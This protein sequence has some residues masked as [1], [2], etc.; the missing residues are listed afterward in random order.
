MSD[1][2]IK[3]TERPLETELLVYAG[4][5]K[6]HR[7]LIY[8]IVGATFVLSVIVSLLLPKAYISTASVFPP[9]QEATI[10]SSILSSQIPMA[11]MGGALSGFLGLKSPADLW[12]G[13]L[14]S[15]TVQDEI[16][17]RFNL[18]EIYGKEKIEDA[19][20]ALEKKI[21][22]SKTKEEIILISVEDRD[23][24]AAARMANA[25]VE[26]LD[27]INKQV[28]MSSGKRTRIFIEKRLVEAREELKKIEG[29]IKSFMEA[30]R[31]VKLDD[32]TRVIIES[33]GALKGQL[34]AKEL[35]YQTIASYAASTNPQVEILKT[36]VDQLRKQLTDLDQGNGGQKDIFMPMAKIP[37]IA[38]RYTTLIRDAKIQETLFELL[39]QQYEMAKIQES[40]DSPIIQVLDYANPPEKKSKPR[41]GLIVATATFASLFISVLLAFL[42]QRFER[43]RLDGGYL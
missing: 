40:K 10:G 36:Q 22:I 20:K 43:I 4:T 1:E 38:E 5:I 9:Q 19:R 3:V 41:R 2:I 33:I 21:S 6:R 34:M 17:K 8:S 27:K 13:I 15:H 37:K 31:A 42:M 30:N 29:E 39:T 16:I 23:P 12:V 35:E 11:G 24:E 28:A 25:F 7:K 32:Q 26:E 18:R 14:M